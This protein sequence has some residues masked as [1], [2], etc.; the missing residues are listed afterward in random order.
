MLQQRTEF[1]AARSAAGADSGCGGIKEFVHGVAA[2]NDG[3][4][5]GVSINVV[6]AADDFGFFLPVRATHFQ[7]A[8][9]RGG[10]R[11]FV[12]SCTTVA[13]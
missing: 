10:P 1:A 2:V 13:R 6:A 9:F 7:E 12:S 3:L 5:N 8:F 11:S 4:L